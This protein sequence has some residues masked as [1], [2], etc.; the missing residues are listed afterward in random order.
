MDGGVSGETA[1]TID[2]ADLAVRL[3][4]ARKIKDSSRRRWVGS[5]LGK[6]PTLN[7]QILHMHHC[8]CALM[9]MTMMV[10]NDYDGDE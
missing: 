10:M 4:K 3:K 5:L 7:V 8:R 9:M 6:D 1:N 2:E